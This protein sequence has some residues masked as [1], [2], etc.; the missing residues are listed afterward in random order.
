[1]ISYYTHKI[2]INRGIAPFTII[3]FWRFFHPILCYWYGHG[4]FHSSIVLLANFLNQDHFYLQNLWTQ[5]TMYKNIGISSYFNLYL[6][7][8][9]LDCPDWTGCTGCTVCFSV[10]WAIWTGNLISNS[11]IFANTS[12]TCAITGPNAYNEL[13]KMINTN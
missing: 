11:W 4:C 13:I 5:S 6:N 10:F 8:F 12:F 2:N 9:P 7:F 3:D 1:M